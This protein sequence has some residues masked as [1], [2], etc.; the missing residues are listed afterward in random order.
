MV[1][2]IAQMYALIIGGLGLVGLFVYG[3]LFGIMNVD[4]NLDILRLVLAGIFIAVIFGTKNARHMSSLLVL[5]GALYIGMGIWGVLDATL[6][7]LL[8]ASLTGFDI[9]FH[10]V[11]GVVALI[12]GLGEFVEDGIALHS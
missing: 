12:V 9:G 6:G 10:L 3:H 11:T 4:T 8:P 2:L 1:K 7:G 5:V